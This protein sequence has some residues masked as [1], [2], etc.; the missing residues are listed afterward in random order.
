MC[1]EK[2]KN[3]NK[4]N[5]IMYQYHHDILF[6]YFNPTQALF[7]GMLQ[8]YESIVLKTSVYIILLAQLSIIIIIFMN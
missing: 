1:N 6:Y 7:D 3:N 4:I 8:Y 5:H 2:V